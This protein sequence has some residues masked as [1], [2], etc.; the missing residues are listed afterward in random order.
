MARGHQIICRQWQFPKDDGAPTSAC[1]VR[2]RY[3]RFEIFLNGHFEMVLNDIFGLG[4]V[5]ETRSSP[6]HL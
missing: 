2:L 1:V 5:K 6:R 3:D 4:I